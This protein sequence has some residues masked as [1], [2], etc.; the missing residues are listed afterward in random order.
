M[1][2][3]DEFLNKVKL[4]EGKEFKEV[5]FSFLFLFFIFLKESN[6][7][8]KKSLF[9][10]NMMKHYFKND[11]LLLKEEEIFEFVK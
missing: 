5:S 8:K 2:V 11:C 4:R 6:W 3:T 10:K 9:P 1:N 7:K